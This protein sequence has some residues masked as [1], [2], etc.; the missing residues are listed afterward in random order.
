MFN[1]Y[2]TKFY[3][4]CEGGGGIGECDD[5]GGDPIDPDTPVDLGDPL[6]GNGDGDRG[7]GDP[8]DDALVT[9]VNY[10]NMDVK[11]FKINLESTKTNMYGESLE[12]WY[13]PPLEVKCLIERAE[14]IN[15]DDEFGVTV[16]NSIVVKI[17]KSLLS[18]YGFLP[19]VGD[20]V[21]DREKMYEINS[22]DQNFITLPGG[23]G[24]QSI[25]GNTT[26][27]TIL[28]ILKGYLTRITKLNLI[29]YYQ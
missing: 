7:D 20:I 26:G 3:G 16:S 27:V 1:N 8:A 25:T 29:E 11:Y 24:Q 28:F 19:E 4:F 15:G 10:M 5:L 22:I 12:K 13:Y 23:T 14:I 9:A 18:T 17:P 6:G 2:L 21:L